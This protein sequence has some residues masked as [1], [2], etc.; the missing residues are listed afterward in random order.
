MGKPFFS[1]L[2]GRLSSRRVVSMGL[3]TLCLRAMAAAVSLPRCLGARPRLHPACSRLFGPSTSGPSTFLKAGPSCLSGQ[4]RWWF[5]PDAN[6]RS[7]HWDK[8]AIT[9]SKYIFIKQHVPVVMLRNMK[10]L[11]KQGQIVNVKRGYAR[12]QLV[13]KG[14]A[15]FATWENIDQFADPALVED[16]ALKARV[17]SER[18]RLPFDWVDDIRLQFVRWARE[19]QNDVLLEPITVWDILRALSADHEL[20]LLPGNLDMPEDGIVGVGYHEVPVRI[21]FRSPDAAAGRYML[22]LQAV[23]QQSLQD[24]LRREEMAKAVAY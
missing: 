17:E 9:G 18:G 23:A 21:A 2:C 16:P 7:G 15:V 11:G 5:D 24:E 10:G 13:P 3:P 8:P 6:R 12:H 22:T 4:R 1:S 14:M 19:D 20:D